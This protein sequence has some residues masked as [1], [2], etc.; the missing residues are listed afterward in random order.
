MRTTLHD[1]APVCSTFWNTGP[2]L[3]ES[4]YGALSGKVASGGAG[5]VDFECSGQLICGET[6]NKCEA[7]PAGARKSADGLLMNPKL[8]VIASE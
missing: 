5:T 4:C 7:A 1:T 6:S 2:S 8:S 3:P